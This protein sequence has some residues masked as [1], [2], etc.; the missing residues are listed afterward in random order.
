[1]QALPPPL[2]LHEK[3][4][5]RNV[6][7]CFTLVETVRPVNAKIIQRASNLLV[8]WSFQAIF[9]SQFSIFLSARHVD[10]IKQIRE[11]LSYTL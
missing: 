5:I 10:S 11:N 3:K 7:K 4:K 1:M 2:I 8:R 6:I 9:Y